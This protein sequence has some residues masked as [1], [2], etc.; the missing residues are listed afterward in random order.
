MKALHSLLRGAG[1][2]ALLLLLLVAGC[3]GGGGGGGAAIPLATTDATGTTTPVQQP[4][5]GRVVSQSIKSA[6]TGA[7][8]NVEV[9]I[10]ASY[11]ANSDPYPTIYALDGDATFNLSETRFTNFRSILEKRGTKA[12]LVGIGGTVRRQEDYNLP[13]AIAYHDFL[14]LELIPLIEAR[15]RADPKKRML[16]GL[17]TSGNLAATALFLEGAKELVFSYFISSEAAF[18]QQLQDVE[19]LEQKMFDSLAGRPLPATLI[20]AQ[21]SDERS[22]NTKYVHAMYTRMAARNYVGLNL[23]E[24]YFPANGHANMDLPAFEDAISRIVGP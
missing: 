2:G 18:W 23:I 24:T 9:F 10:P 4:T 7:T 8:Y 22:C 3:G 21:C 15:Y 20:L 1:A 17:S 16:S 14:S 13:G 5:S 6:K 11:D 12:I 19:A